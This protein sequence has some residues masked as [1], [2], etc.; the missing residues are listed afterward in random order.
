MSRAESELPLP[1]PT[2]PV[3]GDQEHQ[4]LYESRGD[5]QEEVPLA[6]R[7][8]DHTDPE[9]LQISQSAMDE[10]GGLPARPAR[11]VPL[12]DE[13]GA[14]APHR[15]GEGRPRA[16]DPASNHEDVQ[17]LAGHRL[18]VRRAGPCGELLHHPPTANT[19]P[20]FMIPFGSIVVFRLRRRRH[21]S[22]P[23]ASRRYFAC[24]TPTP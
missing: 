20:G 12:L 8:P 7:S 16:D 21:A 17:R 14:V 1:R 19:F 2:I 5:P 6:G 9:L 3:H 23:M 13:A 11:E 22:A 10:A 18:Q 24:S 15:G 4:G